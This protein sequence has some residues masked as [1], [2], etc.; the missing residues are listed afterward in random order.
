VEINF[1]GATNEV[2]IRKGDKFI[3][4]Q[5]VDYKTIHVGKGDLKSIF[6]RDIDGLFKTDFVESIYEGS[7]IALV[8][9]FESKME[10]V[11]M[12]NVGKT[13]R[14]KRFNR[15]FKYILI[16]DGKSSILKTKKKQ[17]IAALGKKKQLDAFIDSGKLKKDRRNH[18]KEIIAY[19]ESIL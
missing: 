15:K 18:L 12:Q 2:E 9:K 17:L 10:E 8:R 6:L 3:E 13:E 16:K 19:Y 4:L 1:N 5:K 11:E 14:I 7:D